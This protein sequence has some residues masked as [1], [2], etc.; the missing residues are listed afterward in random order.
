MKIINRL[1]KKGSL[2]VQER[3][4]KLFTCITSFNFPHNTTKLCIIHTV[5]YNAK[6]CDLKKW[7]FQS[8]TPNNWHQ[9]SIS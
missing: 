4:A 1:T 2:T 9:D 3:Y 6:N 8:H 7:V 5:C